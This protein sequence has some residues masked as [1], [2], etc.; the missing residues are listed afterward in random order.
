[1]G[2]RTL[3]TKRF[4]VMGGGGELRFVDDRGTAVAETIAR[5]AMEEAERIERK[6]SR[7]LPGSVLSQLNRNA[8]RTPV[9]V[10]PETAWLVETAL[11]LAE[12]TGGAFAPTVGALRQVWNFREARVPTREEVEALLPLL[13]YRH[14]SIRNGTVFLRREGMELDLGGIGKEYA[15]DRVAARLREEGVESAVVNLAG[16]LCTVGTRGDGRPWKVGV[17]DPRE[18]GKIRFA[19]RLMGGGGIASSGDYERFFVK[20]GVRYHHLLDA[21]TGYP[22]RGIASAT[23]LASTAFEAGLAATASFLLGPEA[24]LD[25]LERAEGLEGA[26][27]TEAGSLLATSGINACSDLPGSIYADYPTL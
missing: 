10:D 6:Y 12:V 23:A 25:Y 15:V 3:Y 17:Q 7:Y 27:I 11:Q 9:A 5:R 13:D 20:E 8:G 16:D 24:G 18:R 1:M 26:I 14:V 19:L 2:Q 4:R 21:R 22:A